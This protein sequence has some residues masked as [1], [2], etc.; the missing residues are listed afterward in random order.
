MYYPG[1]NRDVPPPHPLLSSPLL[2][3]LVLWSQTRPCHL[4]FSHPPH[5]RQ[6]IKRHQS[7][8]PIPSQIFRSPHISLQIWPRSPQL[9]LPH[10]TS[11]VIAS[12]LFRLP[13]THLAPMCFKLA[14]TRL[15]APA[16]FRFGLPMTP[17]H[18]APSTSSSPSHLIPY[19]L[20]SITITNSSRFRPKRQLCSSVHSSPS[21]RPTSLP[22]LV[23]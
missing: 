5:T 15:I 2:F 1:L 17:V 16:T 21:V 20:A 9:I 6:P 8:H 13:R 12:I 3:V 19:H 18:E 10:L 7:H 23:T 11:P 4:I 22:L 14:A